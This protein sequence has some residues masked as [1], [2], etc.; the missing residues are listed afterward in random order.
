MFD[1]MTLLGAHLAAGALSFPEMSPAL[2]S[3]DFGFIGLG[4]MGDG[5]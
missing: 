5:S 4:I 3:I 2:F 1:T